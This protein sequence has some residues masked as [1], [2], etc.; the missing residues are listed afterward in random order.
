MLDLGRLQRARL[1]WRLP[2]GGGRRLTGETGDVTTQTIAQFGNKTK[3]EMGGVVQ[4]EGPA[5]A[6][7]L[8]FFIVRP[9]GSCL[10]RTPCVSSRSAVRESMFIY[11]LLRWDLSFLNTGLESLGPS[12][13]PS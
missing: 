5:E 3:G 10:P 12:L 6:K 1:L 2:W 11:H 13:L 9:R 8:R 4:A 7:A